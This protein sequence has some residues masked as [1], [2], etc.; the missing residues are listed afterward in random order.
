[1]KKILGPMSSRFKKG[2]G[3]R[4]NI[5][6]TAVKKKVMGKTGRGAFPITV[7]KRK[8]SDGS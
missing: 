8:E 5:K 3:N 2:I 7:L 4:E 1:L 6:R